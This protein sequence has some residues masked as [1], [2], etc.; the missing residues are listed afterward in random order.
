VVTRGTELTEKLNGLIDL[1]NEEKLGDAGLQ[2]SAARYQ[3]PSLISG[4][5]AK[6][7]IKTAGPLCS[8]GLMIAL[9]GLII[10]RR[11]EEKSL[12]IKAA[13]PAA[14]NEV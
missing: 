12:K 8:V 1:L 13:S 5:F 9:A 7:L 10:S 11:K 3:A 14:E 4:A 2:V 6:K